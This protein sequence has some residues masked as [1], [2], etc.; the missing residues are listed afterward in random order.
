[1]AKQG[2]TASETGQEEEENSR[3]KRVTALLM[4]LAIAVGSFGWTGTAM[5]AENK[6]KKAILE[7]AAKLDAES[8]SLRSIVVHVYNGE[9]QALPTEEDTPES[10][11]LKMLA[12]GLEARWDIAGGEDGDVSLSETRAQF[13]Q[14]AEAEMAILQG[15][16]EITFEDPLLDMLSHAYLDCVQA[17][18]NLKDDDPIAYAWA[19]TRMRQ[20]GLK[21]LYFLNRYYG[22]SVRK[23]YKDR[24]NSCLY[25]GALIISEDTIG[26]IWDARNT[27]AEAVPETETAVKEATA[28][29]TDNPPPAT[30]TELFAPAT[31]TDLIAPATPTDLIA[32]ATPTDLIAPATPTD[33]VIPATPTDLAMP[34]TEGAIAPAA[35]YGSEIWH[36]DPTNAYELR[37]HDYDA[38]SMTMMVD[39]QATADATA[40]SKG[41]I[42]LSQ[43]QKYKE[44]RFSVGTFYQADGI[45]LVEGGKISFVLHMN[46][47]VDGRLYKE[48][49]G[50]ISLKLPTTKT[51]SGSAG[52]ETAATATE[53][54]EADEEAHEFAEPR[55]EQ[56][57]MGLKAWDLIRMGYYEQD[58]DT[59]NLREPI[60]W[61]VISVNKKKHVA[62]VIAEYAIETMVYGTE[63]NEDEYVTP[64]INW[65]ISHIREWL[66]GEFYQNNFTKKEKKRIREASNVTADKSG[67]FTTKDHVFLLKADEARR[68]MSSTEKM[69]CKATPYVTAKLGSGSGAIL[70]DG[71][72]LWWLRDMVNAAKL[73]K[74]GNLKKGTCNEAGYV[75]G[76]RGMR[77][78][79][80]KTGGKTYE[81]DVALVRPAMWIEYDAEPK[82]K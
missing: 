56:D 29:P 59:D 12:Y 30:S 38:E 5:A 66:N 37:I 8:G 25:E 54:S 3:M 60:E 17:Q 53:A 15:Y 47:L 19:W 58:G 74:K 9:I 71:Y 80:K 7:Q 64:G 68:Y 18:I 52:T 21:R 31:P 67:R 40:A 13:V 77:A 23:A 14:A 24:M 4:I 81:K 61:R 44:G 62:L 48:V 28:A 6:A 76:S 39:L 46:V 73:D 49:K 41:K 35:R 32:L 42:D 43:W 70:E 78:V 1:M 26:E 51:T 75:Y 22:V 45:E 27:A 33:L 11:W 63:G 2:K 79:L 65:K 72:C 36:A 50:K 10:A 57:F 20:D 34:V 82:K 69:S 55:I 16:R